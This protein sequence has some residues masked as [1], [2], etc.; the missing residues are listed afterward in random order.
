VLV[1]CLAL[2]TE[3]QAV[4]RV[5]FK[6]EGAD[7]TANP[8]LVGLCDLP[9]SGDLVANPDDHYSREKDE[10]GGENQP[11]KLHANHGAAGD[12]RFDPH[13]NSKKPQAASV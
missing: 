2:R 3:R 13:W 1:S 5:G 9:A 7:T 10:E 6:V 12:W 11:R 4:V 8:V